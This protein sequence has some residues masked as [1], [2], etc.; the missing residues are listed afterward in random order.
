MKPYLSMITLGVHNIQRSREFYEGI[1]GF[2]VK[3][4]LDGFVA[5]ELNNLVFGLFPR[6]ALARDLGV[7][8]SSDGFSGITLAH[9]VATDDEVIAI[10]DA[11][12]ASGNPIVKEPTKV[13]WGDCIGAYFAD[14]DGH[15]WEVTSNPS[16]MYTEHIPSDD[17]V[18]KRN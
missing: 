14:P 9:N 18:Q 5:Y 3:V 8:H 10:L 1:L 15:L 17:S 13:D 12:R 7:P 2:P 4:A 11:V 6:D 16:A